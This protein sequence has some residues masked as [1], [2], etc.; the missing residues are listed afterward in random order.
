MYGGFPN[1]QMSVVRSYSFMQIAI[2]QFSDGDQPNAR[3]GVAGGYLCEGRLI[4]QLCDIGQPSDPLG[5][6]PGNS[7]EERL[8]SQLLKGH[9]PTNTVSVGL[10]Y[11]CGGSPDA[12]T[13]Q[14]PSAE[15]PTRRNSWLFALGSPDPSSRRRRATVFPKLGRLWL[16]EQ[17]AA[18]PS[19]SPWRSQQP[20]ERP[21]YRSPQR[22]RPLGRGAPDPSVF[23]Q[24]LRERRYSPFTP[25][26]NRNWR[27]SPPVRFNSTWRSPN[28]GPRRRRR[29]R[30]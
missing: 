2:R 24:Q 11:A 28:S 6:T 7:S 14:K 5:V 13:S 22:S 10:H 16:F 15:C 18:D 4:G 29:A 1:T 30:K 26:K 20:N 3:V 27:P 9:Q 23:G 21:R 8:I 17:G 12:S 19:A 25:R